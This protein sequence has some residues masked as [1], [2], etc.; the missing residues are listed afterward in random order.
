MFMRENLDFRAGL[1]S[2]R[3][4][5]A[6]PPGASATVPLCL[7]VR[8]QC[9]GGQKERTMS[10]LQS[11]LAMTCALALAL[12][13]SEARAGISFIIQSPMAPPPSRT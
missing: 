2:F 6:A 12:I 9:L 5:T 3:T 10:K 4:I 13:A 1:L 8:F 7:F 11:Q